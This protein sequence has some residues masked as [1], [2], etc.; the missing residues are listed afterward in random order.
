MNKLEH[1]HPEYMGFGK[2]DKHLLDENFGRAKGYNGCA[3]LWKKS[4]NNRITRMPELGSDRICVAKFKM[5]QILNCYIVAVYLPHQSCRIASFE[6]EVNVLENVIIECFK[7]GQVLIIGDENVQIALE[8]GRRGSQSQ[9]KHAE[10]LMRMF[11]K[12][13]IT[14]YDVAYASGPM[15]TYEKAGVRTYL[16]HAFVSDGLL[17]YVTKCEVIWRTL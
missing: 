1:I 4:L 10:I 6:E 11:S 17:E 13:N 12:Y 14:C 16:D 7:D 3:L 15:Y 8:Y 9:S 2:H 5:S